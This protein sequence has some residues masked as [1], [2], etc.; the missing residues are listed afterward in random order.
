MTKAPRII[1][2]DDD[3]DLLEIAELSLSSLSPPPSVDTLHLKV[4]TQQ[5]KTAAQVAAIIMVS[6]P[7]LLII[8]HNLGL[9]MKGY[10]I[11][12]ALLELDFSASVILNSGATPD[13]LD[14]YLALERVRF[15]QRPYRVIE[16]QTV[17]QEALQAVLRPVDPDPVL[18]ELVDSDSLLESL[19]SF[20]D[21]LVVGET[22]EPVLADLMTV[23]RQFVQY[24]DG[25]QDET[26]MRRH[27]HMVKNLLAL[28]T[29][30]ELTGEMTEKSCKKIL[31]VL[32][33]C[34]ILLEKSDMD[35]DACDIFTVLSE[36][37]DLYDKLHEL[38][39]GKV[40]KVSLEGATESLLHSPQRLRIILH[41][42]IANAAQA[43]ATAVKLQVGSV[44]DGAIFMSVSDNGSGLPEDFTLPILDEERPRTSTGN[45]LEDV[46]KTAAKAGWI[47]RLEGAQFILEIPSIGLNQSEST[48]V[49]SEEGTEDC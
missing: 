3:K 30:A 22:G 1:I 40:P 48:G 16:F 5:H 42:L 36:I 15:L 18:L 38:T 33:V 41:N 2:V 46:V 26:L 32:K 4:H 34:S 31:D 12:L 28:L 43:G 35:D 14:D 13:S 7:D 10:D 8:D 27:S 45:G 24:L 47:F 44:D 11:L 25:N 17:V 20:E 37:Q 9:E 19:R 39:R 29:R 21:V 49:P 6:P 23:Q